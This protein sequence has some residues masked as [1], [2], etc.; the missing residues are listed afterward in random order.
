M[1]YV[2]GEITEA[3]FKRRLDRIVAFEKTLA[4]NG[5]LILKFWMHLGR[6][7]QKERLEALENDPLQKWLVNET[8]WK[9]WK[10]YDRFIAA[11]EQLI[12]QTSTG[13]SPWHIVEGQDEHYRSLRVG[14]IV[15]NAIETHLESS[16]L[17][18]RFLSENHANGEKD[19]DTDDTAALADISSA[20]D[21]GQKS[22]TILDTL[23]A[24]KQL[25]KKEYKRALK[26]Y[27]SELHMLQRKALSSGTSTVLVFEGSDAAGKGG[28]IRRLTRGLDA[29]DYKVVPFGA[30]TDEEQRHHY[31]W[32]FWK[33]IPRAGRMTIFDR[34]WYGRVLVERVEGFA[35]EDEWK[36]AY[37]EIN[38]FESQLVEHGIVLLKFWINITKEEQLARFEDRANTPHKQWK[39]SD[40]DWR[41]RNNWEQYDLAVHKMVQQTSTAIAPWQ[42]VEGNCKRYSRIKVMRT[43]CE[44]LA[45]AVA[46]GNIAEENSSTSGTDQKPAD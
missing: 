29:V 28:I 15:L 10:L 22:V 14:E 43:V 23:S 19:R 11:A 25:D 26:K 27:T 36:R 8:D 24:T 1:D 46:D 3:E 2:Y 40:E 6:E 33:H 37:A 32:R 16:Q 12:A 4:D 13:D 30:P 9:H 17:H 31:L 34:S 21:E 44:T 38:D 20:S 45:A 7:P 42:M 41:N 5:T 18:D 39:L 35:S